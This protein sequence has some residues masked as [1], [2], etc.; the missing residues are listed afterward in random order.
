MLVEMGSDKPGKLHQPRLA[1]NAFIV[2]QAFEQFITQRLFD[3]I[4]FMRH[5][6]A[7]IGE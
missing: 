3:F 1:N 4:Q 2:P 7:E 6:F 5:F